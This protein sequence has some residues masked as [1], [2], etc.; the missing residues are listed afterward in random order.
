MQYMILIHFKQNEEENSAL[1][2]ELLLR[3]FEVRLQNRSSARHNRLFHKWS[4]FSRKKVRKIW[5][6][7]K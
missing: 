7:S 4:E 5:Y 2:I 3:H 6:D 1:T